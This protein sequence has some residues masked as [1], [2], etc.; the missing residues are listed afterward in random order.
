MIAAGP[1]CYSAEEAEGQDVSTMSGKVIAIDWVSSEIVVRIQLPG[2]I[3]DELTFHVSRDTKITKGLHSLT[4][5]ELHE[6]DR[7]TIEYFNKR[8]KGLHAIHIT[9]AS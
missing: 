6:Q 9:V 8:F 2:G 4:F 1:A 5:G 7:V 3:H